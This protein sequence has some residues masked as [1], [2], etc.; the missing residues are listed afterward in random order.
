MNRFVAVDAIDHEPDDEEALELARRVHV[1]LAC[2]PTFEERMRL[3]RAAVRAGVP[4]V[5][6]AQWGMTGTLV[7]V[8][9]GRTACLECI[10][11]EKPSFE[12]H[13][14]VVGAISM[15]IGAMAA[16][17]AIKILSGTGD[18]AFGRLQMVDGHQD[19][20]V[21]VELQRNPNCPCCGV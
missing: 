15:A 9:P 14:P 6:A 13:F 21:Q 11:P 18:P 7:V 3:N 1:V 20:F 2:P 12:E 10:Y 19:R 5:D 17:E 4:L 16:L 8:D